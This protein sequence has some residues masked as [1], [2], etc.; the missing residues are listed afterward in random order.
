[1]M[2]INKHEF[3]III[4][5]NNITIF[6]QIYPQ[7]NI[8]FKELM[9]IV[10]EMDDNIDYDIYMDIEDQWVPWFHPET[11][12]DLHKWIRLENQKGEI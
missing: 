10:S 5:E 12:I 3:K 11:F 7:F 2:M 9:I 6:E 4:K 1:M 8:A